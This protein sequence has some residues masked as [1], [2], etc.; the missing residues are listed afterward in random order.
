VS[1]A[2]HGTYDYASKTAAGCE[3]AGEPVFLLRAQD[4]HA[5][6]AVR[7]WADSVLDA[8]MPAGSLVRDWELSEMANEAHRIAN[9]MDAWPIKKDPD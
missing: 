7:A 5:A 8:A 1:H 9:E 6:D 2:E 4:A 3:A